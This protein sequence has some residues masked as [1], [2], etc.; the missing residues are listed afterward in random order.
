MPLAFNLPHAEAGAE[1]W[2]AQGGLVGEVLA[3]TARPGGHMIGKR[4]R[5][6]AYV[7]K[8]QGLDLPRVLGRLGKAGMGAQVI[9]KVFAAVPAGA[10]ERVDLEVGSVIVPV[11]RQKE[12]AAVIEQVVDTILAQ[13]AV[14]V[15][16]LDRGLTPSGPDLGSPSWV[17]VTAGR[18]GLIVGQGAN[19]YDAGEVWHT[20]DQ[21]WALPVVVLLEQR[22]VGRAELD[23]FEAVVMV[24]GKYSDI[25]DDGVAALKR[26]TSD[27]GTEMGGGQIRGEDRNA[28]GSG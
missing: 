27:G 3:A 8:S 21:R 22:D 17:K 24:D 28:G 5:G 23:R 9:T 1:R 10:S 16:A 19:P 26:W 25:S 14:E 4:D 11:T 2:K 18:G 13:D 6:L 7:I 12:Q 15:V 20:L